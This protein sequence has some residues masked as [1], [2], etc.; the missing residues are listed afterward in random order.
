MSPGC[1]VG[2]GVAHSH[3]DPSAAEL[4][5]DDSD[6]YDRTAQASRIPRRRRLGP[7]LHKAPNG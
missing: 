5:A 7:L 6:A 2:V 3:T 4:H 1:M